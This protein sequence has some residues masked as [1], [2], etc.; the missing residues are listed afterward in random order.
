M[1]RKNTNVIKRERAFFSNE[2]WNSSGHASLVIFFTM[3]FW[4]AGQWLG[5]NRGWAFEIVFLFDSIAIL[6]FIW[7]L[8]IALK[9]WNKKHSSGD[10]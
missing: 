2:F 1:V 3:T 8:F 10:S 9:I 5:G 6:G 7:S 4:L